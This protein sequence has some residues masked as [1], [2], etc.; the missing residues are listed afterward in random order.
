M[1]RELGKVLSAFWT[2]EGI[3]RGKDPPGF[4]HPM[5]ARCLGWL[6]P[7]SREERKDCEQE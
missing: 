7:N 5:N 3:N 6:V 2:A 1:G 4:G